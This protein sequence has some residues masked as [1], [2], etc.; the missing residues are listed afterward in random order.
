MKNFIPILIIPLL[1]SC[2]N[3]LIVFEGGGW[4]KTGVFELAFKKAGEDAIDCGFH[5]LL[6]KEG[7]KTR[8]IGFECIMRA[9]AQDKAFIYG[10]YRLPL[11][12]YAME[13]LI[14]TSSREYWTVVY[15][16]MLGENESQ[17]WLNL[18]DSIKFHKRKYYYEEK[19]CNE[20]KVEEWL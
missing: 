12:S 5:N 16:R 10:T 15:D 18:C 4:G 20:R 1:V 3:S 13:I 7:R 8:K 14:R 19:N 11:D 2:T 6:T 17:L 9:E